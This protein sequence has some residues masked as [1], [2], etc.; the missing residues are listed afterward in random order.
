M[1]NPFGTPQPDF[2]NPS[3]A[4]DSSPNFGV[5]NTASMPVRRGGMF[6]GGGNLGDI[7]AAGLAGAAGNS[8]LVDA[9]LQ[10]QQLARHQALLD[11]QYQRNRQDS[12]ADF[13]TKAQ[14]S[15][16]Y[17]EPGEFEQA[18]IASGVQPGTPAWTNAMKTRV[19]NILDPTVLTPQGLM[20]RSQVTGAMQSQ[21][22]TDADID[23]LS[24]GTSGNA[25]GGFP[26]Y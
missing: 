17:K 7:I 19:N 20:L 25:G 8:T 12:L 24:G 4:P 22:L 10:R 23:R 3:I 2:G 16:Q 11:Q 5:L 15:S 6:G 21:P 14:I 18:L 1:M 26:G 9:I 13:A